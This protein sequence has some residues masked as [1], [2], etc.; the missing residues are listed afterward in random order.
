[1]A[2]LCGL[3][4]VMRLANFFYRLKICAAFLFPDEMEGIQLSGAL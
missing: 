2:V 1:M 3:K 4:F